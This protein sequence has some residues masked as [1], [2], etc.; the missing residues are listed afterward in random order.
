[1]ANPNV[2]PGLDAYAARTIGRE[3]FI[4]G[5]VAADVE[6][7]DGPTLTGVPRHILDQAGSRLLR[8]THELAP[9][10]VSND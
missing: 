5:V 1:M 7:L 8:R 2:T 9:Y 10:V 6:W 4:E 3:E